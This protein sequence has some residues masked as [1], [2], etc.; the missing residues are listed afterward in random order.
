MFNIGR[1]TQWAFANG[2]G[3][4][5]KADPEIIGLAILILRQVAIPSLY[6]GGLISEVLLTGNLEEIA[7]MTDFTYTRSH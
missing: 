7:P 3:V 2:L 6:K 5:L 1:A 4:N